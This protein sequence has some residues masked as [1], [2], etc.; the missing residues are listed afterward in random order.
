MPRKHIKISPKTRLPLGCVVTFDGMQDYM[1]IKH[2]T[3]RSKSSGNLLERALWQS[4]CPTC[5]TPFTTW[6]L[7]TAWPEQRRCPNH[8]SAGSCV[9]S[10]EG[11]PRHKKA[12]VFESPETHDKRGR[13]FPDFPITRR[14]LRGESEVEFTTRLARIDDWEVAYDLV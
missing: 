9:T 2:D 10:V 12:L 8:K 3:Y 7:S 13:P 14:R 5:D 1:I 6:A 11:G 4:H